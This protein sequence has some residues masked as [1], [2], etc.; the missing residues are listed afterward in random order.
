MYP[1]KIGIKEEEKFG[2][3]DHILNPFMTEAVIIQK[4]VHRFA[5][6]INDWFLCDNGLRRER[7]NNEIELF[8][9]HSS[10][11]GDVNDSWDEM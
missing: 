7:V 8:I 1:L 10:E 5:S 4:P 2:I 11:N 6:Q 9:I 3:M